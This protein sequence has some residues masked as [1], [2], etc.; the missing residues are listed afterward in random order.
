MDKHEV[1]EFLSNVGFPEY[2]TAV[3]KHGIDHVVDFLELDE[4]DWT[5]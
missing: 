3:R 1:D 4:S 2:I 5:V